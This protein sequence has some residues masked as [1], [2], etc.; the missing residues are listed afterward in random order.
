M[1]GKQSFPLLISADG[2]G[3]WQARGLFRVR[4]SAVRSPSGRGSLHIPELDGLRGL[5]VLWVILYHLQVHWPGRMHF[6]AGVASMGWMGVDIFFALSGFLITRILL[7]CERDAGGLRNF[8]IKRALRIWP[9]Y[10]CLLALFCCELVW[11]RAPYPVFRCAVFVQNYLPQFVYPHN[12]DQTWSLC[13]EEHIYLVWPILVLFLPRASLPWLLL[14][15]LAGCPA[16]RWAAVQH[17]VSAKLIYTASQYRLDSIALGSLLA[18]LRQAEPRRCSPARL[19]S[20]GTA[21]LAV[22]A[23]ALIWFWRQ[24]PGSFGSL[25]V[26]LFLALVS[27]SSLCVALTSAGTWAGAVLAAGPLRYAGK[28]SYGLYMIHP[29]VF[30]AVSRKAQSLGGLAAAGVLS[31]VLAAL[32][33]R[34][35]ERRVLEWRTVL[36][37][38]KGES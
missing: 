33:W 22:S 32:S 37:Q 11:T 23:P 14:S 13:V 35:M 2:G 31:F 19:R 16:L 10:Y 15:V 28:I 24:S 6:F 5:A 12:F 4:L 30:G 25:P 27:G 34:F 26:Y 29:F 17:G 7:R 3:D 1:T 8:Y 36:L 21:V 20:A 18:C 9:L 38:R